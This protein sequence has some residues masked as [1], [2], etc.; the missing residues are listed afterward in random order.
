[1]CFLNEFE[2]FLLITVLKT[3]AISKNDEGSVEKLKD[4]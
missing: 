3:H 1:M 2:N 4:S